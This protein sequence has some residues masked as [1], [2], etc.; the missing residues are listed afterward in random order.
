LVAATGPLRQRIRL[1]ESV[2]EKTGIVAL[3]PTW[4]LWSQ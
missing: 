4:I 2:P 1:F 3:L